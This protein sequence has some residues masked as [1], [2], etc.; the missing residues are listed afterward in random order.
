MVRNESVG[1]SHASHSR[2]RMSAIVTKTWGIVMGGGIQSSG[3]ELGKFDSYVRALRSRSRL[4]S[5]AALPLPS[6]A[7]MRIRGGC[8]MAGVA[9][10][11][12]AS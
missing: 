5:K 11:R 3:S 9:R 8:P 10:S 4:R 2:F 6:G 7:G 12:S 1:R